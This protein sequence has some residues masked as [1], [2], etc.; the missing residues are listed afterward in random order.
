MCM[1]KNNNQHPTQTSIKCSWQLYIVAQIRDFKCL[2][3]E[4]I[5]KQMNKETLF[6]NELLIHTLALN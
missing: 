2:S 4:Q 5:D 6:C 1:Y 3:A